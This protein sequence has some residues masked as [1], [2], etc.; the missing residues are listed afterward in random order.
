MRRAL[1][2]AVLIAC[3]AGAAWAQS[4]YFTYEQ[5]T[6]GVNAPAKSL[7]ATTIQPAGREQ[8]AGCYVRVETASVRYRIDGTAPTGAVGLPL[9]PTVEPSMTLSLLAAQNFQ[10]IQH[11]SASTTA[12]VNVSC[13]Q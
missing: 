9:S 8:I 10:V 3:C 7:A 12:L 5:L 13:F 1:T 2:V 11:S 4:R 6:A